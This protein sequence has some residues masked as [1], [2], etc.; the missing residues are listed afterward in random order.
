MGTPLGSKGAVQKELS[1]VLFVSGVL[2]HLVLGS[3]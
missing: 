3:T 2:L 1:V